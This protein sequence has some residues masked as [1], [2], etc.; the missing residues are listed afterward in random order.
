MVSFGSVKLACYYELFL[1][2]FIPYRV[3]LSSGNPEIRLYELS[4]INIWSRINIWSVTDPETVQ[5]R[6]AK[7]FL[8]KTEMKDN[9][10]IMNMCA[11]Y[12]ADGHK[13]SGFVHSAMI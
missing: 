5:N 3:M 6:D 4:H 9:V 2:Y 1:E 12:K 10:I 8:N 7:L 11:M 13:M